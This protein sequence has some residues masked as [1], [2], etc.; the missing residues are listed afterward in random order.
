MKK[1][2]NPEQV[3]DLL[4][5]AASTADVV[6][7]ASLIHTAAATGTQTFTRP[8]LVELWAARW[9]HHLSVRAG[10][11]RPELR[12]N[13][14]L[15]NL[16]SVGAVT[17]LQGQKFG[18]ADADRLEFLASR[19]HTAEALDRQ[20]PTSNTVPVGRA[21]RAT[22]QRLVHGPTADPP[23]TPPNGPPSAG[24]GN[25]SPA[26]TRTA[27]SAVAVT[28]GAPEEGGNPAAVLLYRAGMGL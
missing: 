13:R 10:R 12:I 7:L 19:V 2:R 18:V 1:E 22:A 16:I 23:G 15:P 5:T 6:R 27:D 20:R 11:R 28:T 24:R 4:M 26:A 14:A 9:R 3:L 8:L 17:G 21:E 25:P